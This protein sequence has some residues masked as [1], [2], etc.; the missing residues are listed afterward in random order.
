[1]MKWYKNEFKSKVSLIISIGLIS[2]ILVLVLCYLSKKIN[3]IYVLG[4]FFSFYLI[5]ATIYEI[6][7]NT[8]IVKIKQNLGKNLSHLGFGLLIMSVTLNSFFSNFVK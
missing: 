4:L 7:L 8:K 5:S 2:L 6:A 1:M 3:I